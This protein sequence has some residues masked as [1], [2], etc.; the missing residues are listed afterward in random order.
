MPSLPFLSLKKTP[1]CFGWRCARSRG[2]GNHGLIDTFINFQHVPWP[3]IRCGKP[4]KAEEIQ[5]NHADRVP[6]ASSSAGSDFFSK[7]SG[8]I[9][10]QGNLFLRFTMHLCLWSCTGPRPSGTHLEPACHVLVGG[11]EAAAACVCDSIVVGKEFRAFISNHAAGV[12]ANS[13]QFFSDIQQS[14][15]KL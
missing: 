1:E 7:F 10:A 2:R 3:T 6:W 9:L 12:P 8:L 5:K 4:W 13:Y 11:L 14:C 15:R